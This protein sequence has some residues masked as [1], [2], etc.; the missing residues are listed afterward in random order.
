V[1]LLVLTTEP[2]SAQQLR[3]VVSDGVD[4]A[5]VEVLVVAPALHENAFQ[6]W[7]SDADEAIA[8]ADAVREQTV[9]SLGR[10]GVE[11]ASDTGES[12][13]VKAVEDT[14]ATFDADRIVVF[15]RGAE[16]RRYLE[17]VDSGELERRFGVPVYHATV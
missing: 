12:D 4:P 5:Q 13:P 15:T 17:D 3:G 7:L 2:I 9:R 1:R 14:L 11:A 6:F 8:R 10:S 16:G